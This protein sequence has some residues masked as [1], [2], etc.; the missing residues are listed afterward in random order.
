MSELLIEKIKSNSDKENKIIIE[1]IKDKNLYSS[2]FI[3]SNGETLLH[4]C[5]A[6]NNY[7]LLDYILSNKLIHV[8]IMNYRST[9]PIYY[10]V[11]E[12]H[13]EAI[14][15]FI[16]HYANTSMRSGFSGILPINKLSDKECKKLIID[17]EKKNIP[18]SYPDSSFLG[19]PT[20]KN[21]FTHYQTILFMIYMYYNSCLFCKYNPHKHT[22]EEPKYNKDFLEIYEKEGINGVSKLC[23]EKLKL[24]VDSLSS[25]KEYC[26]GC[27]KKTSLKKCSRCKKAKFCSRKCQKKVF[28]FHKQYCKKI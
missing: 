20:K 28:K 22:F 5:A 3:S 14:N 2:E 27:H 18:F 4:W 1:L 12:N 8:N 17:Y 25:D 26:S 13:K 15:I 9:S 16:K 11:L 19:V 24:F 7:K 6:Y 21:S 23:D 10:A